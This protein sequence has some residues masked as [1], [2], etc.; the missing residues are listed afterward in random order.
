MEEREARWPVTNSGRRSSSG[1]PQ[2]SA[3]PHVTRQNRDWCWY[4]LDGAPLPPV[5]PLSADPRDVVPTLM[6]TRDAL[7]GVVAALTV[8]KLFTGRVPSGVHFAAD[9]LNAAEILALLSRDALVTGV[10]LTF[11][12][13]EK[14]GVND[15]R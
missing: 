9:V 11:P 15:D 7:G 12:T 10:K 6:D 14:K 13:I 1:P 4:R 3:T 2:G 5:L 8:R